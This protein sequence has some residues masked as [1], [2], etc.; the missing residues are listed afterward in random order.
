MKRSRFFKTLFGGAL[1]VAAAGKAAADPKKST[2]AS[3][4]WKI[5]DKLPLNPMDGEMVIFENSLYCRSD[6][7]WYKFTRSF[8]S[9]PAV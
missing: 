2:R 5:V 7:R 9:R 6:G 3:I 4:A 8:G 1:G